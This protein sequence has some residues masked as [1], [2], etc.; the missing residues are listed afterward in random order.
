MKTKKN[1]DFP[2]QKLTTEVTF[3]DRAYIE[4]R[5]PGK[6]KKRNRR[7]S[8]LVLRPGGA[9][10]LENLSRSFAAAR[11]VRCLNGMNHILLS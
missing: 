5:Q 11:F 10:V 7:R 4:I 2:L 3:L 8:A 1:V 6:K 9:A